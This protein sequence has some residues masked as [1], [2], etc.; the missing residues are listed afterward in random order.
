VLRQQIIA[1]IPYNYFVASMGISYS[2]P[3]VVVLPVLPTL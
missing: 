3:L 2:L 1:G